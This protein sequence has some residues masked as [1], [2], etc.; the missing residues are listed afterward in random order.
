MKRTTRLLP[1]LLCLLALTSYTPSAAGSSSG[2][3][4]QSSSTAS[5]ITDALFRSV[6]EEPGGTARYEADFGAY[7]LPAGW[8]P[9]QEHSTPDQVFFVAQG[10]QD[11]PRPDNVAIRM[12]R[13]PY[14]KDEH[15]QFRDA[16]L[17][18]LGAQLQGSAGVTLLGD[19]TYTDNG[20]VLY[21]F[22]VQEED[23]GIT[24]TQYYVVGDHCYCLIHE[25]NFTGGSGADE[26]AATA[27][28]T[29]VWGE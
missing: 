2:T 10:A 22:T 5:S 15:E 27:A 25:T 3:S 29:F 17:Q 21:K 26:A 16:I 23:T 8:V 6:T 28:R 7:S 19:G 11:Q 13:N 4:S 14:A 20:D 24:T 9:A 18:Q 12:G 1:I